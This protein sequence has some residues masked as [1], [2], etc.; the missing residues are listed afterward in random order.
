MTSTLRKILVGSI[1]LVAFFAVAGGALFFTTNTSAQVDEG[2]P[3]QFIQDTIAPD[4]EAEGDGFVRSLAR[5]FRAGNAFGRGEIS[6]EDIAERAGVDADELQ[7]LLDAGSTL[8]E[9]LTELGVEVPEFDGRGRRGSRGH[10]G[11]LSKDEKAAVVADT[12]G[13]TVEELQ[14]AYEAGTDL[15]ELAEANNVDE[16]TIK[17]AIYDAEVEAVNEAVANGDITQ[18]QAD[19]ILAKMELRRLADQII[20]ED[21]LK[22][23][24]AETIG[25][26]VE[27]VEAAK[28]D[29]TLGDIMEANGVTSEDV[30]EAVEAAKTEMVN[31]AVADGTI[32]QEQADEI[33]SMSDCSKG[34]GSGGRGRGGFRGQPNFTPPVTSEGDA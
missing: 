16:Q 11:F 25:L 17:D 3:I 29:D 14:A 26:S 13:I 6:T 21:A 9:A 8:P 15:S 18:E 24:A 22:A 2:T 7:S 34:R 10:D 12:L 33:L 32:T 27:E 1:A 30:H 19:E 4:G 20:D 23:V 5:G 28:E 31:A